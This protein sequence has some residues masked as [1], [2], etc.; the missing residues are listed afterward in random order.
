EPTGAERHYSERL[1]PLPGL[2]CCYAAPAVVPA[3]LRRE[4]I[5]AGASDVL[6]LCAQSLFKYL[7]QDDDLLVKIAAAVPRARFVLFSGTLAP[8]RRLF[9]DRLTSRFAAAVLDAQ[10]RLIMLPTLTEA[11]FLGVGRL[12]DVLLDSIGWSGFNTT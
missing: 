7:P 2:G 8:V 12:T 4:D 10:K 3:P 1:V 5:G 6:Y 11:G 9:L